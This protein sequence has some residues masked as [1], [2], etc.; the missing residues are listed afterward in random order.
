MPP[1]S[2]VP[3]DEGPRDRRRVG[4]FWLEEG[5]GLVLAGAAIL[6]VFAV[7]YVIAT[8]NRPH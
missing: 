8:L 4:P 2:T 1:S 5:T 6:L 7:L 3:I